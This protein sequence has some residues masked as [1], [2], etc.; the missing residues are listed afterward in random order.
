V[1]IRPT[2]LLGALALVIAGARDRSPLRVEHGALVIHQRSYWLTDGV[3]PS[4]IASVD[5][6]LT[7]TPDSDSTTASRYSF[8]YRFEP[9]HYAQASFG[10]G[11]LALSAGSLPTMRLAPPRKVFENSAGALTTALVQLPE[12][13]LHYP[14]DPKTGWTDSLHIKMGFGR[15]TVDLTHERALRT[16]NSSSRRGHWVTD[17]GALRLKSIATIEVELQGSTRVNAVLSGWVVDTLLVDEDSGRVDNLQSHGEFRGILVFQ[18]P[19]GRADTIRGTWV[20]EREGG[21][22]PDPSEL[23]GARMHYFMIHGRD[24]GTAAPSPFQSLAE[25]AQNGDTLIFDSLLRA[26]AKAKSPFD[27]ALIDSALWFEGVPDSNPA[28]FLRTAVADYRPGND[29]LLLRLF[30]TWQY[31]SQHASADISMSAAMARM[32]AGQLTS[33]H[34][35]HGVLLDREEVF[36]RLVGALGSPRGGGVTIDAAP[37][38]AQA[39][40]RTDDPD[41]RDLLVLAA[42]EGDP[43]RYLPLLQRLADSVAGFGPIARQYAKGNN[44]MTGWSWGLSPGQHIEGVAFPGVHAD[45]HDLAQYIERTP[46]APVKRQPNGFGWFAKDSEPKPVLQQWLAAHGVD[47]HAEFRRRF[48]DDR[49]ERARLVWAQYVLMW[50]DTLPIPWLRKVGARDDGD[51]SNRAWNLLLEHV[52]VADTVRDAA[53][54][55]DIQSALLKDLTGQEPLADTSGQPPRHMA[56]HNERPDQSFLLVDNLTDSTKVAWGKTF[57]LM[58]RDSVRSIAKHHGLQMAWEISAVSRYKDVYSVS[59]DLLPYG[60]P[61]LC[62]GGSSYLLTRR[63]G[64]WV[65]LSV[66]SWVS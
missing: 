51:V 14:R 50:G 29:E 17:S 54:L 30:M 25:R 41:A 15:D 7:I 33:L 18:S 46:D 66:G 24:S 48:M 45:W 40:E 57:T 8:Q 27:R 12:W 1:L 56:A 65:V 22:G 43:P 63:K 26:R 49:V 59:V 2:L 23:A 19:G 36:S 62:G 9:A 52:N 55:T 10:K 64:K 44:E 58:S 11:H 42:Y 39:A 31:R 28:R 35:E 21:W 16:V 32:V 4:G 60:G 37:I 6:T 20:V 3:D 34:A 5:T 13:F 47:G 53:V 38:L 61:C